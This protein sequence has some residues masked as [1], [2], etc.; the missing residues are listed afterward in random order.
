MFKKVALSLLILAF[1]VGASLGTSVNAESTTLNMPGPL[2]ESTVMSIYAPPFVNVG[3]ASAEWLFIYDTIIGNNEELIPEHPRL[4]TNWESSEDELEWTVELREDVKF[5]DG[6]EFTA[7]D[8]KATIELQSHP[9]LGPGPYVEWSDPFE[10]LEGYDAYYA[11]DADHIEGI[12]I[13]DDYNVKFTHT[14]PNGLFLLG[15]GITTV[16]PAH[17]IENLD[18]TALDREDYFE[19]PIGT[20]PFKLVEIEE[21]EY[22]RFEAFEDYFRGEPKIDEALLQEIDPSLAVADEIADY[23]ATFTL[24]VIHEAEEAAPYYNIEFTSPLRSQYFR[25]NISEPPF[26]DIKFREALLKGIDREEII[27]VF[28]DGFAEAHDGVLSPG[29]WH[30]DELQVREYDPERAEELVEE[31]VYEGETLELLEYYGDEHTEDM[32]TAIQHMWGEIGVDVEVRYVD[33][34][35]ATEMVWGDLIDDFKGE[36]IMYAARAYSDPGW[37]TTYKQDA[38]MNYLWWGTDE[39]DEALEGLITA[40]EPEQR[41]EYSYEAQA[42]M[43]EHLAPIGLWSPDMANIANQDLEVPIEPIPGFWYPVDLRLHEWE[44]N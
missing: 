43:D 2:A 40:T 27:E 32:M 1:F 44:F 9:D 25:L 37:M 16:M 20:G 11:G 3:N 15:L 42:I 41:Q 33:A 5:H 30:N 24:D 35:T 10:T 17:E 7:E 39:L 26:N 21:G 36:A 4:A 14:E 18:P 31:S 8:V 29:F 38:E 12:E 28:Y 6:E 34:A 19:N 13:V 23:Y 22:Y